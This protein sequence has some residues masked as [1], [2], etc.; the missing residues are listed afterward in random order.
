M[1]SE[2]NIF[3]QKLLNIKGIV[4]IYH[5][6]QKMCTSAHMCSTTSCEK[7]T[8]STIHATKIYDSELPIGDIYEYY[9]VIKQA[10]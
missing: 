6:Q 1:S 8:M 2:N 4:S 5:N 7:N 3:M 10:H 9:R